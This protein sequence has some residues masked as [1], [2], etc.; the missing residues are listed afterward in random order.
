MGVPTLYMRMLAE[1]A[2]TPAACSH[3]RL[4]IAG[5]APLLPETFDAWRARTGHAILE[6]YGM[7]ETVML[8]SNPYR[9]EDGERRAG[10]AGRALPGVQVRIHDEKGQPCHSGEVGGIEVKGPNVFKGYWRMPEKTAEEFTPDLWFKTGDVGKLD[11]HGVLTHRRPQ[12]GSHHQRRLQRLSGRDRGLPQ[13]AARR[14]RER[15]HRRAARRLRRSRGRGGGGPARRRARRRGAD[16]GAEGPH[17][18]L[19]GAQAGLRRRPN[20]RATRWARCRRTCCASGT[21][22]C[23]LHT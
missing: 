1:P 23:F 22:G 14:G 20:C 10:T 16:R 3:M 8:T 18:Q 6:R 12:Q 4:F 15:R 17:R 19:Q 21:R 7:S 13:R 11:E 5:S 9:A 2:L